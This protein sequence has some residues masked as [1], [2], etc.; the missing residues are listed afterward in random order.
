[1]LI[2]A[3]DGWRKWAL[4][5]VPGGGRWTDGAVAL[6][7]DAAHAMLPFAAQG[8]AM[9]IE[10][11]AVLAKCM[12][13]RQNESPAGF[14]AALHRYAQLRRPR[15]TRLQRSAQRSGTIYH[16]SGPLALARD[17]GIRA[18]GPQRMLSRQGWIYNWQV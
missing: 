3:V 17:L 8:A 4:F 6:L 12:A 2:G 18:M 10:D 1:M 14:A 5:T 15:V 7:G 13:E 16:L 9:A 11:A